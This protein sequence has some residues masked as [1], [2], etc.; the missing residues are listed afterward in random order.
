MKPEV[1]GLRT[2]MAAH[3]AG[4][5]LKPGLPRRAIG[6]DQLSGLREFASQF[7]G[8]RSPRDAPNPYYRGAPKPIPPGPGTKRP[9]SNPKRNSIRASAALD[10]GPKSGS[11][12]TAMRVCWQNKFYSRD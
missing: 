3:R 11:Q 9:R 10:Q 1:T 7:A 12:P 4:F 8:I 2:R 5:A 6:D